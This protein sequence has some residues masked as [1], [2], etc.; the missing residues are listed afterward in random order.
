M[1]DKWT[2]QNVTCLNR[3]RVA[4]FFILLCLMQKHKMNM[5]GFQVFTAKSVMLHNVV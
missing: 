4:S 5:V 2:Q 1:L 3:T